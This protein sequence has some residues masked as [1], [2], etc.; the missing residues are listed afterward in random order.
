M[1]RFP[2]WEVWFEKTLGP[3]HQR[4]RFVGKVWTVLRGSER[5]SNS[6]M[7]PYEVRY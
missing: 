4:D 5:T 6:P 3:L 1:V 2:V 7:L